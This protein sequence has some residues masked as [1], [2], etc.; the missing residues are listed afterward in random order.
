MN[1]KISYGLHDRELEAI[2]AEAD[3]RLKTDTNK[4]AKHHALA[5]QP[6]LKGDMLDPFFGPTTA[7][8]SKLCVTV[9]ERTQPETRSTQARAESEQFR[10][11]CDAIDTQINELATYNKSAR[12]ELEGKTR[13]KKGLPKLIRLAWDA[14]IY[15]ADIAFNTMAFEFLRHGLLISIIC[16]LFVA[17]GTYVA[18][19]G[20][21]HFLERTKTERVKA[22]M[23]IG[24]ITAVLVAIFYGLALGRASLMGDQEHF[25]G[26]WFFFA[27]NVFLLL[28]SV[29]ISKRF[30]TKAAVSP[31]QATINQQF[32]TVE[33]NEANIATLS[34]Q[35]IQ[36]E[37]AHN[38]RML[39]HVQL[40][41]MTTHA[42]YLVQALY[43]ESFAVFKSTNMLYRPDRRT[44]DCFSSPL[45][46]LDSV[47][48]LPTITL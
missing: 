14:C 23:M 43:R 9:V 38:T 44:P 42:L 41:S 32:E 46:P 26:P 48:S 5:S 2:I 40:I 27:M 31:E 11:K 34:A 4:R 10:K 15:G 33:Q 37:N 24:I 22:Y 20:I 30:S 6:A 19:W 1:N 3:V 47:P 13:P 45:P 7:G 18:S 16:A 21:L 25:V 8:Y 17:L 35:R 28:T 12:Y 36:L 29:L 39:E